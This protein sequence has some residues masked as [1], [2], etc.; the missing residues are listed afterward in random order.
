[1]DELDIADSKAAF[2]LINSLSGSLPKTDEVHNALRILQGTVLELEAWKKLKDPAVLH[3]NL[4]AGKPAKV[5]AASLL[6]LVGA[7]ECSNAGGCKNKHEQADGAVA[8]PDILVPVSGE[9][10]QSVIKKT[11]VS[12]LSDEDYSAIEKWLSSTEGQQAMRNAIL[13]ANEVIARSVE[14]NQTDPEV[15]QRAIGPLRR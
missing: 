11:Q 6:H 7:G 2:M 10:A 13:G 14:S 8:H 9:K 1:M 3:A 4:L 15:W 5:S 12:S